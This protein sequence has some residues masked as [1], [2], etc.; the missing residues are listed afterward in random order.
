MA[1]PLPRGAPFAHG[2]A[3]NALFKHP[4]RVSLLSI[5][6]HSVTRS[7]RHRGPPSRR[8]ARPCDEGASSLS[9]KTTEEDDEDD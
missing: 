2:G 6:L 3:A 7:P 4:R 1:A 9:C 8:G 5:A